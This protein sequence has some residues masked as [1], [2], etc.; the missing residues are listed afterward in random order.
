MVQN[1]PSSDSDTSAIPTPVNLTDR[2]RSTFSPLLFGVRDSDSDSEPPTTM[3]TDADIDLDTASPPVQAAG[4]G[5]T[6]LSLDD[7]KLILAALKHGPSKNLTKPRFG[8]ITSTGA[9]TG[10]GAG[11]EGFDPYSNYCMREFNID[12]HKNHQSMHPI[13]DKCKQGLRDTPELLFGLSH[14]MSVQSIVTSIRAFEK[15]MVEC[16]MDGV[17]SIVGRDLTI[18][19]FLQEPGLVTQAIVDTWC[20][21]LLVSGVAT[22][23]PDG[24]IKTAPVCSYDRVNLHWSGEALLNSCSPALRQDLENHVSIKDRNGPNLLM[25]M[26]LMIYRPSQSKI[27]ALRRQLGA[28]DIRKYPAE[29]ISLFCLDASKLV[30]EIKMNFME[31]VIVNDLTTVALKGLIH[32]SDEL[33]RFKVKTISMEND[34]NGFGGTLGNKKADALQTLRDIT[35]MHRVIKNMAEPDAPS[36]NPKVSAYQASTGDQLVQDRTF[37]HFHPLS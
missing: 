13:Q 33:I 18:L 36:A 20:K 23:D 3:M 27:E 32:C 31:G 34:V 9:W 22:L 12:I 24:S 15:V 30:R 37:F 11:G 29:D 2:I 5:P 28:L 16:G 7:L 6:T 4:T 1:S 17:F 21:D 8:G 25:A 26:L 14:E 35:A 10:M 19:Q